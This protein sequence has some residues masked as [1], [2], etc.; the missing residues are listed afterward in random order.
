MSNHPRTISIEFDIADL[1]MLAHAM[2][3][4]RNCQ[5][6][7]RNYIARERA[8]A[9]AKQLAAAAPKVSRHFDDAVFCELVVAV[10]ETPEPTIEIERPSWRT[11]GSEGFI[12]VTAGERKYRSANSDHIP[13]CAALGEIRD[14]I[15]EI[16]PIAAPASPAL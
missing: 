11:W 6:G 14:F 4:Q 13:E 2:M 5:L 10:Y 3:I 7:T 9:I 16:S 15:A 12:T 1:A 8:D